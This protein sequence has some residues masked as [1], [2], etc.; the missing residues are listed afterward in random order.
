MSAS[1]VVPTEAPGAGVDCDPYCVLEVL[2]E[3]T[4]PKQGAAENTKYKTVCKVSMS[5]ARLETGR[6]G[7]GM[8]TVGVRPATSHPYNTGTKHA[9]FSPEQTG[10]GRGFRR[11]CWL[12]VALLY[13]NLRRAL[14]GG[15]RTF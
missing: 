3:G 13:S 10:G 2:P 5:F 4:R 15:Q 11:D 12:C 8:H 7:G 9:G 6:G 14:D 1:D